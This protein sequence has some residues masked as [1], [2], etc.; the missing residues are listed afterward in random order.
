MPP[1]VAFK[2]GSPGSGAHLASLVALAGDQF[3]TA[4]QNDANASVSA[5][6]KCFIGFYGVYDMH[7]Q[8][9]HD[10]GVRPNDKIVEKWPLRFAASDVDVVPV[11]SVFEN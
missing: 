1:G 10:L 3:T 6:V 9:T 5:K 7:A 2:D 8:W 4:Y 11:A